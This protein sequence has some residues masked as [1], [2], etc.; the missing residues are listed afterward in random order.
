MTEFCT[1]EQLKTL[2][3]RYDKGF[4]GKNSEFLS[5]SNSC[6]PKFIK[7]GIVRDFEEPEESQNSSSESISC[8]IPGCVNIF[9]SAR[10]YESHYN[11]VHRYTC[12]TCHKHLPSPHLLDLHIE[13]T[14]DSFFA[15]TAARKPNFACYVEECCHKSIDAAA[16]RDHCIKVHKF[17]HDFRFDKVVKAKKKK[18][19]E[20][21][22]DV[23]DKN[24]SEK[25]F[26][27]P[28][29]FHFGH[30]SVKGFSKPRKPK[31]SIL[32]AENPMT[33]LMESLP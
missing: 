27:V 6:L 17:P 24:S 10:E 31:K 15:V 9:N 20:M 28:K 11:S 33:D 2:L 30:S 12:N 8:N 32:E 23:Q 25:V 18:N 1:V 16:R 3:L 22:V 7:H 4:Q 14:H 21:E 29:A 26:E 5:G 19:L 13:E